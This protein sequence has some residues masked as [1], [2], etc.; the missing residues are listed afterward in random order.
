MLA[1]QYGFTALFYLQPV[2]FGKTTLSPYEETQLEAATVYREFFE[3]CYVEITRESTNV[4]GFRDISSI[5]SDREEPCFLDFMHIDEE[6]NGLV[7]EVIARD[8]MAVLLS[9]AP[10]RPTEAIK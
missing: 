8:L 4:A 3:N 5:L 7:A 10:T 1:K 9:D 2:I 6:A